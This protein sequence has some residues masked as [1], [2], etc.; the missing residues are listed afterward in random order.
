MLG[1]DEE[2]GDLRLGAAELDEVVVVERLGDAS[3]G[4]RAHGSCSARRAAS[5]A[6]IAS[7]AKATARP[8][9]A[10][11]V[12]DSHVSGAAREQGRLDASRPGAELV[13]PLRA[14]GLGGLARDVVD[15]EQRSERLGDG[16]L[17]VGRPARRE[18]A[19]IAWSAAFAIA[20]AP[21]GAARPRLPRVGA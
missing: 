5:Q 17:L 2:L 13:G 6:S 15:L 11:S 21:R 4:Q 12:P 9:V 10:S 8:R 1:A 19:V 18:P 20:A 7:S 16:Q 3:D 14:A